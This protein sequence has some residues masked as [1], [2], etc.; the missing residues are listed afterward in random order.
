VELVLQMLANERDLV[1]RRVGVTVD[2][3]GLKPPQR[4]R[5]ILERQ[6]LFAVDPN[7]R[8]IMEVLVARQHDA[9]VRGEF[10]EA[11]GAV[12]DEIARTHEVL[13]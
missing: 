10:G 12:A 5:T 13:A 7:I 9:I 6:E 11:I 3:A 8:G 1:C 4:R 2:L